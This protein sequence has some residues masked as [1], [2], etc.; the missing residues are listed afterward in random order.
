M[1]QPPIRLSD[2]PREERLVA[3]YARA[4]AATED[5]RASRTPKP[6]WW[7]RMLSR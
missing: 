2:L 5:W 4:A 6:S 1:P 7:E 3:L